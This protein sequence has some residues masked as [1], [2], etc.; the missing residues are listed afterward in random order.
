M[1]R[2]GLEDEAILDEATALIAEEGIGGF[3]L[4]G[5]ARRLGV[6]SASLYNHVSSLDDLIARVARRA[7]DQMNEALHRAVKDRRRAEAVRALF[8][9]YHAYAH[10]NPEMYQVVLS[11]PM[12]PSA[13][14]TDVAAQIVDPIQE[15]LAGYDLSPDLRVHCE[16]LMRSMLHGF[17]SLEHQGYLSHFDPPA[18]ESYRFATDRA[19]EM[20]E[21]AEE[22]S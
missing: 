9:A 18:E 2:R 1:G 11:L 8:R 7:M 17:A 15:A 5:L 20:L 6:Q 4:R 10:E 16:R 13:R 19:C 22:L 3:S 21:R 12:M 14:A